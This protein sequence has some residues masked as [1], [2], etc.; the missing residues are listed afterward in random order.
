M[1]TVMAFLLF[2]AS[3]PLA[4]DDVSGVWDL[5]MSWT[6]NSHSTGVC[7]FKQ[8]GEKLSG[9]CGGTDKFPITG[10]VNGKKVTW[11]MDVQQNGNKGTMT[12]A[13]VLDDARTTVKGSCSIVGGQEGTFTMKKR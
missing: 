3:A 7:T 2:V 6:A 4:A 11:R 10:D 9:D 1:I 12:F 13:G 5:E 8:D